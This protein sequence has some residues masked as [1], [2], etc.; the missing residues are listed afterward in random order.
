MDKLRA[1]QVF[2]QV[3]ERGSFSRAADALR[4]SR[5]SVT[6]IVRNL[7]R[8]LGARLLDR[9]TRRV[10][11]T[12]EGVFYYGRCVRILRAVEESERFVLDD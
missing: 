7:E 6:D 11:V 3:V 2:A 10:D 9:T 4:M 8:H 1:M 5:S 12:R